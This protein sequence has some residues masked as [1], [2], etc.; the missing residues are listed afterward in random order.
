[1]G[2]S[3]ALA[4]YAA[5]REQGGEHAAQSFEAQGLHYAVERRGGRLI[6]SEERRDPQ[7]KPITRVEAEIRFVLGSGTRGLSYLIERDGFLF[8]SPIGWYAQE[9]KWDLSPGYATR[10][11]HFERQ[12]EPDCLACHANRFE[13]IEGTVSGYRR[14][15]FRGLNIGCE[16][17]HGPGSLHA[18]DPRII[19]A[20]DERDFTIVNPRQLEPALR[21]AV[22]EQCH[23]QG[24][25]HVERAGRRAADYRPGLALEEFLAIYVAT[26]RQAGEN[27]AV[28]HAEQMHASRCF[29]DSSGRLGCISCHDPHKKP[30]P[31]RAVVFYRERC[32][33]CHADRGCTL[34]LAT[35]LAR[36]SGDDCAFCHMP[37]N[38]LADIAHT[39]ATNHRIPR[40]PTQTPARP[41]VFSQGDI[42]IALY[43]VERFGP[44]DRLGRDRDLAIAMAHLSRTSVGPAAARLAQLALPGLEKA[45]R[46]WPD[47]LAA[48]DALAAVLAAQGRFAEGL[49]AARAV[50]KREPRRERALELA[51]A[52]AAQLHKRSEA[53]DLGAR[54]LA[55]NPWKTQYHFAMAQLY[56]RGDD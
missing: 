24:V 25:Y 51:T 48:G 12:I 23:L 26:P 43:H 49:Q 21:E 29:Q 34:A 33:A 41:A 19:K 14:P 39:A 47:D 42:P 17:C 3:L 7:G 36:A 37:K 56:V 9:R 28:S 4:E 53:L 35:R 18:S 11:Y 13:R 15:I 20:S 27:Q 8:Q 6:H 1:M 55:V 40:L 10:N 30:E 31:A 32:L 54:T 22:C 45:V 2:R 46:A 50:L 52:L 44:A 16:R 5:E 38:P